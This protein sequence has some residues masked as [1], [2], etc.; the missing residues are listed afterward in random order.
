MRSRAEVDLVVALAK[1]GA[2]QSEIAR[3]TGISRTTVRDWL[4]GRTPSRAENPA[5]SLPALPAAPYAYLLGLYLGDGTIARFPRTFCLRI[6]LDMRYPRIIGEC[7]RATRAVRPQNRVW[8][9]RRGPIRCVVVQT[10]SKWWPAL[11][12]QH[13]VGTKHERPIIL[14]D[15]Q[16][17]MTHAHPQLFLRGLLHSDGTR[18]MNRIRHGDRIYEYPR[19]QF[20]NRSEDIKAI[21]CEHLDLLGIAWRRANAMNISIARREAVAALDE[22]V[23]PKR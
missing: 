5:A 23:G 21:F 16:R 13:G 18:F 22:F 1:A 14:T 4:A 3:L 10:Y 7:V 8:V 19:Y 6:Y 12:P 20:A 9:G 2:N 17:A 11:F 15:W